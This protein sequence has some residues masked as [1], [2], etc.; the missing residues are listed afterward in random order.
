M[1][2]FTS[3]PVAIMLLRVT[4]HNTWQVDYEDPILGISLL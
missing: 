2:I 3:L 4:N 1:F